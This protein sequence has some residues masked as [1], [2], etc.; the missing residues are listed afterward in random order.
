M[1]KS[2]NIGV[3]GGGVIGTSVAYYCA[4]EGF[5]VTLVEAGE[6]ASGTSSKCEG[7]FLVSDKLPGY[8]SQ[9]SRLSLELYG[10]LQDELDCPV[11]I[12]HK[13]SLLVAETD[14]EMEKMAELCRLQRDAGLA[15][16][17][18]DRKEL[19]EEVPLIADDIPGA[20]E[21]AIDGALNPMALCNA[22]AY[23]TK[24]LGGRVVSR[25]PVNA[26]RQKTGGGFAIR[27]AGDTFNADVVVNCGGVWAPEIAAMVGLK[28]PVEP[29]Q[30]QLIVA[31]QTCRPAP[32]K[33]YE[34]GYMMAK[35][36][37][38]DYV[39][40]VPRN[41]EEEMVT[42]IYEPTESHNF[43]LGG[44]R[45]FC[46]MDTSTDIK[47]LKAIAQRAVR[48]IPAL[49]DIKVIR[50]FAGLRPYTP[51]H[52]PI[53]SDTSVPG[54]YIAAGHEGDGISF[55]PITGRLIAQMVKG[56]SLPIDPKPLR[57][58]RFPLA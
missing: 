47:V 19:R 8:D 35:F 4:K 12:S 58:D 2:I 34:F 23:Q 38:G 43:L 57:Y 50:T 6:I 14:V 16:R 18:M 52:M 33:M 10:S 3:V 1:N 29:R 15:V 40:P 9:L 46:G 11:E 36:Q 48:F 51:D 39:R 27:T 22:F 25:A 42:F 26:I 44:S 53:I 31:E 32:R 37:S 41:I 24:K 30:G 20:C 21:T 28:V 55:A 49:K 45:R 17:M 13:G 5:D 7:D 54:Y 56:E